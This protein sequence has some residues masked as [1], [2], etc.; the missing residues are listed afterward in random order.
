M[1]IE[2]CAAR[3]VS[4]FVMPGGLVVVRLNPYHLES[5]ACFKA[6]MIEA[7]A[8]SLICHMNII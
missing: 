3:T 7:F 1:V 4:R 8:I 6:V 2:P 5:R